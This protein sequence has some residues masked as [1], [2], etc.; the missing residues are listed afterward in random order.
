MR[1]AGGSTPAGI[2]RSIGDLAA[3]DAIKIGGPEDIEVT[4]PDVAELILVDVPLRFEPVGVW[5][6]D[7]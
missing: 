3:G 2:S 4:T 6:A 1:T 7:V 5:A